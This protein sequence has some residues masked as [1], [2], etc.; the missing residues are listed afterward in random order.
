MDDCEKKT[1]IALR[2]AD[3]GG[4]TRIKLPRDTKVVII[5]NGHLEQE[6]ELTAVTSSSETVKEFL[7]WYCYAILTAVVCLGLAGLLL[8][9][10]FPRGI[11][12]HGSSIRHEP[13]FR[14]VEEAKDKA[15]GTDKFKGFVNLK[16]KTKIR[17]INNNYI[18]I[19]I[20][21]ISGK[22][23]IFDHVQKPYKNASQVEMPMRSDVNLTADLQNIFLSHELGFMAKYC[24]DRHKETHTI[25]VNIELTLRYRT[26]LGREGRVPAANVVN[27]VSCGIKDTEIEGGRKIPKTEWRF[28]FE[29]KGPHEASQGEGGGKHESVARP[30]KEL[31]IFNNTHGKAPEGRSKEGEQREQERQSETAENTILS[32]GAQGELG[33]SEKQV[34]EELSKTEGGMRLDGS[35]GDTQGSTYER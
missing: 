30:E 28:L 18:P 35:E 14:I 17:V 12:I 34:R 8:F 6:V 11:E 7:K 21:E 19:K 5:H 2:S 16:Y 32:G 3:G 26:F 13:Y 33:F 24:N 29:G 25:I 15:N 31:V 20:E 27:E 23:T 22:I 10:L 9:F 4:K 1:E